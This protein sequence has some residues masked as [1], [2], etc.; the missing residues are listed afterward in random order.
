[1]QY[2]VKTIEQSVLGLSELRQS[3]LSLSELVLRGARESWFGT[4]LS[5]CSLSY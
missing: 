3:V 1:M 2:F 5:M 4:M